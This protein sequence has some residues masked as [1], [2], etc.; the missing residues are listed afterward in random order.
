MSD[1]K[2]AD[3]SVPVSHALLG[4]GQ[5]T[6]PSRARRGAS[7]HQGG[8]LGTYPGPLPLHT[9]GEGHDSA[10]IG[11]AGSRRQAAGQNAA[12]AGASV[13]LLDQAG[14]TGWERH[15]CQQ[16][17]WSPESPTPEERSAAISHT[18]SEAVGTK[19]LAFLPHRMLSLPSG[20]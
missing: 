5:A 20:I 9:T 2:P 6:L 14:R 7:S 19:A 8:T 4:T 1:F 3:L 17:R 15:A 13:E 11:F 18:E 10:V 12:G 16:R